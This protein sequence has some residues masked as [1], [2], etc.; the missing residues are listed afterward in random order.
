MKS[1]RKR[2]LSLLMALV[3]VCSLLVLPASAAGEGAGGP[4]PDAGD[5]APGDSGE[6]PPDVFA[7]APA[8]GEPDEEPAELSGEAVTVVSYSANP[9]PH[10]RYSGDYFRYGV[11]LGELISFFGNVYANLSDGRQVKGL[12][13]LKEP[14]KLYDVGTYTDELIEVEF[15]SVDGTKLRFPAPSATDTFTIYP[16]SVNCN[17]SNAAKVICANDP[18]NL[19]DKLRAY[20]ISGVESSFGGTY[21]YGGQWE[22]V[23]F[24]VEWGDFQGSFNPKGLMQTWGTPYS[25]HPAS[26][27]TGNPHLDDNLG[28]KSLC[29]SIS[30]SVRVIAVNAVQTFDTPSL[31]VTKAAVSALQSDDWGAL[32]LPGTVR[33]H[34]TP[35]GTMSG[36]VFNDTPGE[37]AISA[38]KKENGD[39]LT[40]EDLQTL[41]ANAA[42]G[43]AEITLTPVY[44]TEGDNAVPAWATVPEDKYPT[45]TLTITGKIP[46]AVAVTP[47]AA[48]EPQTSIVYGEE[49]GEPMAGQTA[50]G[51]TDPNGT[52]IYTY[53]GAEGTVYGPSTEKP[54]DAGTYRVIA[55]L[56]SETHSG[57]EISDPFTIQ[58]RNVSLNY[59]EI[60]GSV[61]RKEFDGSS[62]GQGDLPDEA[63]VG[64]CD[65]DDMSVR[66]SINFGDDDAEEKKNGTYSCYLDGTAKSN[67]VLEGSDEWGA[68]RG[69]ITTSIIPRPLTIDDSGI[70]VSKGNDGTTAPGLLRG[71][72]KL[73]NKLDIYYDDTG[74]VDVDM[75]KVEVGEYA[76][77]APG[78]DKT[79]TLSN[80]T[81]IGT[82]AHN[83]SIAP[84]YEFHRAE[85]AGKP[86]PKLNTDFKVA[87][88]E[89]SVYDGTSRSAVFQGVS[90]GLG[91]EKIAYAKR[92][93]DGKTY[94][95]PTTDAPVNA[96]TY[97]VLVSFG[98]SD[99]FAAVQDNNAIEAGT[100]I[101]NKTAKGT[102]AAAVTVGDIASSKVVYAKDLGLADGMALGAKNKEVPG[103]T[104]TESNSQLLV[105]MVKEEESEGPVLRRAYG[106]VGHEYIY[107]DFKSDKTGGQEQSFEL[108]LASDNYEE[109]IVTVTVRVASDGLRFIPP[110]VTVKEPGTFEY[111]TYLGNILSLEEDGLATLNGKPVQGRFGLGAAPEH[112]VAYGCYG[113][114]TYSQD[115]FRV[116]FTS[117]SD[118]YSSIPVPLT[119]SVTFTIQPAHT[120]DENFENASYF[121]A[122]YFITIYANHQ[123]NTSPESL[124]ELV[125]EKI[126][127]Y[128]AGYGE[129]S[130][131][132]V[133]FKATW[134]ADNNEPFD[135]KG[136]E[137]DKWYSHSASLAAEDPGI[138]E[139]YE[140]DITAPKAYIQVIPVIAVQKSFSIPSKTVTRT[141]VAG[142][143]AVDWK[144]GLGLPQAVNVSYKPSENICGD[145][146]GFIDY[147]NQA[148]EAY[149]ISG[150][151]TEDGAAFDFTALRNMANAASG[152]YDRTVTLTP[153][154]AASGEGAV[155]A[156]A[157]VPENETPKFT[158]TITNRQ[159]VGVAVT[160]P[161]AISPK[162]RIVYGDEYTAPT[163]TQEA[164]GSGGTDLNGRF[165][166]TYVGVN[167]TE[168]RSRMKPSDAGSYQ[169]T[170]ALESATHNGEGTS[171]IFTICRAAKGSAA[172]TVIVPAG[173]AGE[174]TIPLSALGL[175]KGLS[176]GAKIKT[177][178]KVESGPVL[179]GV[180]GKINEDFITLKTKEAVDG[181]SQS[182]RLNLASD[183]YEALTV[184]VTVK[185]STDALSFVPPAVVVREPRTFQ[186][187]TP[188]R[189]IVTLLGG[190]AALNGDTVP[191]KFTAKEPDTPYAAGEHIN[192]KIE[193]L[194]H[195]TS[196]VYTDVHV[197]DVKIAGGF[198]IRQ[199]EVAALDPGEP[200]DYWLTIYA[201]NPYNESLAKLAGFVQE[202]KGTY[203]VKYSDGTTGDFAVAWRADSGQTFTSKGTGKDSGGAYVWYDYTADF[204]NAALPSNFKKPKAHVRVM[205]VRAYQTAFREPSGTVAGPVVAA[206]TE[207]GWKTGL[208]LPD[209]ISVNYEPI[210]T[211]AYAEPFENTPGTYSITGWRMDGKD[212]ALQALQAKAAGIPAGA[213]SIQVRLTPVC[214][215]SNPVWATAVSTPPAPVFTLT[216]TKEV[217]IPE[218][219]KS[220]AETGILGLTEGGAVA[221]IRWNEEETP[222]ILY[223]ACYNGDNRLTSIR[224]F[225][226]TLK[227]GINLAAIAKPS[228]PKDGELRL[229]LV[230]DNTPLCAAW[231]NRL[232]QSRPY[233]FRTER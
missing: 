73:N 52:F 188:L 66:Y 190:A 180:A 223:A 48:I 63:V 24:Q 19:P 81:L 221:G 54:R 150:W 174:R 159:L 2:L 201:N 200:E 86:W 193:I 157:T 136:T 13:V 183:N 125:A 230:S 213:E 18:N 177:A 171:G 217:P 1:D 47:P 115:D 51:G 140:L 187:G 127:R 129:G 169:V 195:S 109:L 12:F 175:E 197:A 45:L 232:D 172:A 222:A 148:D 229:F 49:Y 95:A 99:Q 133:T 116:S 186:Y 145:G 74:R 138:N 4:A 118:G 156:W 97:K 14:E 123:A 68:V 124:K 62:Y 104:E 130:N 189:D 226:V 112:E 5:L 192:E 209:Q 55:A 165:I 105:W 10:H 37:Y 203:K 164:A 101:I 83:Y 126:S 32:G 163:A 113:V 178:P 144:T 22:H 153:V 93:A 108:V 39:L 53:V 114:G 196:G 69:R 89:E 210:E 227:K 70:T 224:A 154:Y 205:P 58:R 27:T 202:Q 102:A 6:E 151:R 44:A 26:L 71:T 132:G 50:A 41:A 9:E 91:R 219:W 146:V 76:D 139:N 92:K 77:A 155:P 65:G 75:S 3:M 194:F 90:G 176:K 211:P 25:F 166:Y 131:A 149:T 161:A 137:K 184:T 135:P 212:L 103:K 60:T 206:M 100:F 33:V 106:R 162:T 57:R 15:T 218:E 121:K 181:R 122:G 158:L 80:I 167:G 147:E 61:F 28:V 142:L 185:V 216:I 35:V 231:S 220:A 128:R 16:A 233:Y 191:G 85:I 7:D 179:T 38:W 204:P 98:E 42:D 120:T 110:T 72:L 96:G 173:A 168:Y 8:P 143:N 34:Y 111:G 141:A 88:P 21:K 214:A 152:G 46:V 79:V 23:T 17:I 36:M 199:A 20:A 56:E 43:E 225:S 228:V 208:G 67:Y 31:T 30:L 117:S 87:I 134:H 207:S 40:Y 82:D 29:D 170:A 94:D 119:Q 59:A 215:V 84:A 160:T 107:L 64:K 11:P 182:F 78:T 198:T